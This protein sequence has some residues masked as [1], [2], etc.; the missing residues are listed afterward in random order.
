MTL[1]ETGNVALVVVQVTVMLLMLLPIASVEP[2]PLEIVQVW[3]V[4]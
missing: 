1:T 4:G 3:P 2:E